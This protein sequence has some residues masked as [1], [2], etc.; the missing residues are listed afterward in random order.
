MGSILYRVESTSPGI[1]AKDLKAKVLTQ[2]EGNRE[3][4]KNVSPCPKKSRFV[5]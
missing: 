2:T 5:F 4:R 3:R 1:A